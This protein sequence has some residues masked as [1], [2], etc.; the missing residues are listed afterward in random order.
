MTT[1]KL[2]LNTK[3]ESVGLQ[4]G[5]YTRVAK[6][7]GVSLTH[8]REIALG[9]RTGKPSIYRQLAKRGWINPLPTGAK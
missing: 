8:V 4:H 6:L 9:Y 5:D 2:I 1:P 3:P 7:C